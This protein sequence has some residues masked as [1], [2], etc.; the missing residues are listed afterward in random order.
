MIK[1]QKKILFTCRYWNV[2]QPILRVNTQMTRVRTE[3]ST[4]RVVA[5]NS[6]VTLTP[7]KLKNAILPMLTVVVKDTCINTHGA[8]NYTHKQIP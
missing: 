1:I 4:M 5:D 3:S 2:S 7:A 8:L 6:L